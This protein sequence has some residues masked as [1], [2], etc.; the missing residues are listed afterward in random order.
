MPA[1]NPTKSDAADAD[2]PD[3]ILDRMQVGWSAERTATIGVAAGAVASAL[4][5]AM[6]LLDRYGH[7]DFTFQTGHH[8]TVG[9]LAATLAGL[10]V[11]RRRAAAAGYAAWMGAYAF[12][13]PVL[14][15]AI[16]PLVGA[17]EAVAY[18]AVLVQVGAVWAVV[19]LLL[20]LF[21]SWLQRWTQK[22]LAGPQTE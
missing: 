2:A 11:E 6:I 12:L 16:E 4:W 21:K 8:M 9:A 20:F 1:T 10:T 3:T 19:A 5:A 17:A 15:A 7:L 22:R 14:L 18:G 13:L